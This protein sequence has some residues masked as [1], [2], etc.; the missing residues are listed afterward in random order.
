VF[1]ACTTRVL[2]YDGSERHGAAHGGGRELEGPS[3]RG[4]GGV[5]RVVLLLYHDGGALEGA[6]CRRQ[7][8]WRTGDSGG[9]LSC[10]LGRLR[11]PSERLYVVV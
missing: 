3:R 5:Y 8:P 4:R 1:G 9:S 2:H 10:A 11:S 6:R 7:R